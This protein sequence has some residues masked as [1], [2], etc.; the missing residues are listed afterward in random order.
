MLEGS[1]G[2][3]EEAVEW[4]QAGREEIGDEAAIINGVDKRGGRSRPRLLVGG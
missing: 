3:G 1:D 4:R 2:G